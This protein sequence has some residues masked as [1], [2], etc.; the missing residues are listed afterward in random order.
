MKK[1][2]T[3]EK[4]LL[5]N[6]WYAVTSVDR[7]VDKFEMAEFYS[8]SYSFTNEMFDL[9]LLLNHYGFNADKIFNWSKKGEFVLYLESSKSYINDIKNSNIE[10][11]NELIDELKETVKQN[12]N[13][14]DIYQKVHVAI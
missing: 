2:Q 13:N 7:H 14:N 11:Y 9:V 6:I 5:I 12:A 10:S 8:Y 4:L 1:I 3:L